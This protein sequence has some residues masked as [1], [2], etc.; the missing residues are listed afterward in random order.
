MC[1]LQRGPPEQLQRMQ[2]QEK[3]PGHETHPSQIQPKPEQ[4]QAK[5]KKPNRPATSTSPKRGTQQHW[6]H[7]RRDQLANQCKKE[8]AN[9]QRKHSHANPDVSH[10]EIRPELSTI[11]SPH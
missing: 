10:E 1:K 3:P 9:S 11:T 8:P 5:G 7:R 2:C 6:T 4:T